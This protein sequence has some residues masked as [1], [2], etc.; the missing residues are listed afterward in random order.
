MAG[1]RLLKHDLSKA[2]LFSS[3]RSSNTSPTFTNSSSS[4]RWLL[5][6]WSRPPVFSAQIPKIGTKTRM[7]GFCLLKHR[8][9]KT[10]LLS[11]L[12][13]SNI[14]PIFTKAFSSR[15]WLL[16]RWSCPPGFS[17]H[18]H[19]TLICHRMIGLCLLKQSHRSRMCSLASS[20][21]VYISGFSQVRKRQLMAARS[22]VSTQRFCSYTQNSD[23]LTDDRTLS[24]Q[25]KSSQSNVFSGLVAPRIYLRV[26]TNT[27]NVSS[28]LLGRWV[29]YTSVLCSSIQKVGIEVG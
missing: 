23:A 1:F 11:S 16:G 13:S 26:F 14:S 25:M 21:L 28:W 27:N 17:A 5:G 4:T 22:L 6:G 3:F 8:H 19:K 29:S 2:M 12:R 7:A 24:A 15:R 20:L 9:S 10:M 18:I